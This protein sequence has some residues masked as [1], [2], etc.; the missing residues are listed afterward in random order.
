[1]LISLTKPGNFYDPETKLRLEYGE[2]KE[3][4][5]IGSLTRQV[6]NGGGIVM[7]SPPVTPEPIIEPKAPIVVTKEASTI[8]LI[9][10]KDEDVPVEKPKATITTKT[11]G[12]RGRPKKVN[13]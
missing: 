3:V 2:V 11:K 9:I 13:R 10:E 6:L 8:E 5:H 7:V 4:S 1:M 12:K